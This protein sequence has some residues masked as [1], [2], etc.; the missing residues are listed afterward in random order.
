[1]RTDDDYDAERF[2]DP[3]IVTVFKNMHCVD[4]HMSDATV[5]DG[6]S[7]ITLYSKRNRSDPDCVCDDDDPECMCNWRFELEVSSGE[8]GSFRELIHKA[9]DQANTITRCTKCDQTMF[10]HKETTCCV[11]CF[12][13]E[14]VDEKLPKNM[15]CP[16]CLEHFPVTSEVKLAKCR[17]SLCKGCHQKICTS[18]GRKCPL[19]RQE[20]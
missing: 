18:G 9:V 7:C 3:G 12:M 1:M 15:E 6:E 11:S 19:C 4:V 2:R 13:Q 14:L 5:E 8:G 10:R 20:F 17:H 16:V